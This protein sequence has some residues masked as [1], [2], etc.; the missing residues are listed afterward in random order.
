[1]GAD[2]GSP[3]NETLAY[4]NEAGKRGVNFAVLPENCR[5]R[6]GKGA[7][8]FYPPEV[9]RGPDA[10]TINAVAAIAK[11]YK[12][13]AGKYQFGNSTF[14]SSDVKNLGRFLFVYYGRDFRKIGFLSR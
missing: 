6:P 1:M 13:S 4:L 8:R 12:M 11:K 3:W 7:R 14:I 5:G 9:I 2:G 10:H